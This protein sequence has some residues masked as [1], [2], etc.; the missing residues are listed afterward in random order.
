[1]PI[2]SDIVYVFKLNGE[3]K[4]LHYR[5]IPFSGWSELK[6]QLGFTPTTL[7]E[8]LVGGDLEAVG[9]MIWLERK[10]RE[11]MLRWNDVRRELE[12]DEV[13]FEG[14]GMIADGQVVAGEEDEVRAADPTT[15]GVS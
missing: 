9:A 4:E 12:R 5:K 10:Q 15:A 3:R 1:M 11:R 7:L 14:V 13:D 2:V 8:S 6:S